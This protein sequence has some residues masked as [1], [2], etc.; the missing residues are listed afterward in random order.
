MDVGSVGSIIDT[1]KAW[2]FPLS[3]IFLFFVYP[4][5]LLLWTIVEGQAAG[6]A[7]KAKALGLPAP[8][9]KAQACGQGKL[10]KAKPAVA[11]L[12]KRVHGLHLRDATGEKG[13][14]GHRSGLISAVIAILGCGSLVLTSQTI[15]FAVGRTYN[16]ATSTKQTALHPTPRGIG[17]DPLSESTAQLPFSQQPGSVVIASCAGFVGMA[18]AVCYAWGQPSGVAVKSCSEKPR[19][20]GSKTMQRKPSGILRRCSSSSKVTYTRCNA[21]GEASGSQEATPGI[22]W[23]PTPPDTGLSMWHN[24]DVHVKTW[25]DEST[26]LF[27]YINEIPRGAL[28]KFELQTKLVQNVIREDTKG[29]RKLRAFGQPVPFNY[30]CMPQ[31]FRDP[32]ETDDLYNAPGDDDPLDVLSLTSDVAGVGEVVICRPLGMVCLIDEGQADWKII[33]V[34]TE[35]N[36]PLASA[37]TIEEAEEIAPGRIEEA[38]RWMDD[39]KQHSSKNNTTLHFEVHDA[40]RAIKIIE[41]DHAAWKRLI[42]DADSSGFAGGHWV[43]SPQS[44]TAGHAQVLPFGWTGLT[45]ARHVPTSLAGSTNPKRFQPTYAMGRALTM[46]RQTS[47]NSDGGDSS[48]SGISGSPRSSDSDLGA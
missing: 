28:Q 10:F 40:S 26:G 25:L 29:S 31:T 11:P 45:G 20:S 37:R 2:V 48:A 42:A 35:A 33:V 22:Q 41:Q 18:V 15:N 43:G 47:A 46:R 34:N 32:K 36:C 7:N 9:A 27:R 24:V 38:L 5:L 19:H 13:S 44:E 8:S 21:D 1:L 6:R 17:E 4:L 39:F 30:G 12:M 16:S 14:T 3:A 23:Y